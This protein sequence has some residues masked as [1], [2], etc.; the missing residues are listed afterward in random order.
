MK[1]RESGRGSTPP[2]T[3]RWAALKRLN[4][5]CFRCPRVWTRIGAPPRGDSTLNSRRS[6]ALLVAIGALVASLVI[7][8]WGLTSGSVADAATTSG[9]IFGS[10]VPAHPANPDSA[11]VEL[12]ARF[13]AAVN[14]TVSAVRFY[15]GTGNTG[16]HT[17]MLYGPTGILLK[18]V[19]FTG[20]SATGWQQAMFSAPV[21]VTAGVTYTV[22]YVAPNGRYAGD[23]NYQFPRVSGDL[24]ALSGVYK[25]GGGYPTSVWLSSNYY[26]DVVFTPT[27]TATAPVRTPPPANG[28]FSVSP[29]GQILDPAGKEFVPVGV[30]ANGP[31]WVWADPTIGQSDKM[32][33]WR[34]NT[35]RINTC[36]PGGCPISDTQPAH[37]DWHTN[38]DLDSIVNE[39]A[40]KKYVVMI[41]VHQ[42]GG[43]LWT[44][45][46]PELIDWWK[47]TAAKYKDNP[48]VW[49]NFINEPTTGEIGSDPNVLNE[50]NDLQSQLSAAVRPI[51]P[52][53]IIVMDGNGYG[54]EKGTWACNPD[55]PANGAWQGWVDP[56]KNS[57][58]V[59]K[60]PALQAAYGPVVFSLH[61]YGEWGGNEAGGCTPALWDQTFQVFVDKVHSLGLAMLIGETGS[62]TEKVNEEWF[63]SGAWQA[64]HML[65][66]VLPNENLKL[67]VLWWHGSGTSPYSLYF[68]WGAWTDV[69]PNADQTLNW[70]G[71]F[72]LD[73]A[74]QVNP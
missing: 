8:V 70:H 30:N 27:V 25:Y 32:D 24:T 42:W 69:P 39:Y 35:L 9:T 46:I 57:A 43:N 23:N 45:H 68:P 61:V 36:F 50:W 49:F 56:Y 14:G 5:G 13:K 63:D 47:T 52:N 37:W 4:T 31:D 51:A 19:T 28:W 73:Y 62:A 48:Y 74:H 6:R 58:F 72:M 64:V 38:D 12:G 2:E 7:S 33:I 59:K 53:N 22:S 1:P 54:Q 18:S 3:L 67:G 15:K 29:S 40:A 10:A 55:A 60:G 26:V 21:A 41:A 20:E 11:T 17:G 44:N 71:Q 65:A 16:N 34:F 66:R